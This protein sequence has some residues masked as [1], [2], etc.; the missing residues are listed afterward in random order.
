MR[1]RLRRTRVRRYT[2]EAGAGLDDEYTAV[3]LIHQGRTDSDSPRSRWS[4]EE[5]AD[6]YALNPDLDAAWLNEEKTMKRMLAAGSGLLLCFAVAVAQPAS[7]SDDAEFRRILVERID[8]NHQSVGIAVGVVE[9]VGRRVVGYGRLNA[10]DARQ[11]DGD[12]VFEIGSIT[13]V[14]TSTILADMVERG[15]VSLDDSVRR[16]LPADV[17]VPTRN[18]API[19]S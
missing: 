11:P 13:K 6:P 9:L 12:T 7:V 1:R 3:V 4:V 19:T 15:E 2:R 17:R 5:P 10:D 14:F 16:R 18:A 8:T